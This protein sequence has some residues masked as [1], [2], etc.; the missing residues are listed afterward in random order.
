MNYKRKYY[1]INF[2]VLNLSLQIITIKLKNY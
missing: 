2:K 1:I